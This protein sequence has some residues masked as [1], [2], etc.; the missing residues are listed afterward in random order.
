MRHDNEGGPKRSL[1]MAEYVV[2]QSESLPHGA[3]DGE[4][5]CRRRMATA[6]K[7]ISG[8]GIATECGFGRRPP[9]SIGPLLELHD[10]LV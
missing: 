8:Y 6:D 4:D 3:Q 2:V 10:R 7:F 5:G 1:P 9:E